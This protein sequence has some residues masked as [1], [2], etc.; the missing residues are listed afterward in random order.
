M[1]HVKLIAAVLTVVMLAACASTRRISEIR[2]FPGKYDARTVAI[3]GEVTSSW[4]VPFVPLRFYQVDDG[5][6]QMT[7][8]AEGTRVPTRGA[9]VRVKGKLSEVGTFGDRT[10]GLHLKQESVDVRR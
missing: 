1:R 2:Q 9:H 8:L 4:S 6:G 5:T 3:E 10:V 7:V